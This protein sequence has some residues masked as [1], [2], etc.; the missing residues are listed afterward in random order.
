MEKNT[1]MSMTTQNVYMQTRP[2][3]QKE[4]N[5]V[6]LSYFHLETIVAG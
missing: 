1:S 4:K 5:K 6:C 3:G 2:L